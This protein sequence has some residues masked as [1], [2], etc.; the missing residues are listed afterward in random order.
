MNT[1][2]TAIVLTFRPPTPAETKW[3]TTANFEDGQRRSN[4]MRPTAML[5]VALLTGCASARLPPLTSAAA[6][7]ERITAEEGLSCKYLRNV[8]YVA[9]VTGMGKTYELVHQA[10]ENGLR[11]EVA[12]VGG[13]AYV[14]ARMDADTLW[15]HVDYSG[16]A[17]RCSPKVLASFGFT[18]QSWH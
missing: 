11:N 8:E 7:V 2:P 5:I 6:H 14:N 17:F 16:Q 4:Y 10:G 1:I 15:G 18:G 9:K 12:S 3:N 13:N